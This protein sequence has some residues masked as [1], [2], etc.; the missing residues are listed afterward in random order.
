MASQVTPV[1]I[2][3]QY[4]RQGKQMT[5]V[6]NAGNHVCGVRGGV[7]VQVKQFLKGRR[8]GGEREGYEVPNDSN[9]SP[10]H[11]SCR[12]HHQHLH[13]LEARVRAASHPHRPVDGA[14]GGSGSPHAVHTTLQNSISIINKCRRC[15][16]SI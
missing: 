3:Q 6:H 9:L 12:S 2:V 5:D 4:K 14:P 8:K 1:L 15:V 7:G 13:L 10:S 11:A 16:C